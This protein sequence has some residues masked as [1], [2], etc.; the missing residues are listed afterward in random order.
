MMVLIDWKLAALVV[1]LVTAM[2]V[3]VE[4][5]N[6]GSHQTYYL[7]RWK[8]VVVA[9]VTTAVVLTAVVMT[10]VVMTVVVMTVVVMTEKMTEWEKEVYWRKVF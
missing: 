10:V 2:V 4:V 8:V 6:Q 3:T 7:T 5:K 1:L 9:E